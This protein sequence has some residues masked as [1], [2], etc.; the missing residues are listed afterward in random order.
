MIARATYYHNGAGRYDEH[1]EVYDGIVGQLLDLQ[2]LS[3]TN[4]SKLLL[5]TNDGRG[6][7]KL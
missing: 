7:T 1:R 4:F 6:P 2:V 3:L 5:R